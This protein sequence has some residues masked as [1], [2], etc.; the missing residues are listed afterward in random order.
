MRALHEKKGK[1][2]LYLLK[3]NPE[4]GAHEGQQWQ[5]TRAPKGWGLSAAALHLQAC[6]YMQTLLR[7]GFSRLSSSMVA[8]CVT[9]S[10]WR[11]LD[12]LVLMLQ[13]AHLSPWCGSAAWGL[14]AGRLIRSML[15]RR[16]GTGLQWSGSNLHCSKPLLEDLPVM[17]VWKEGLLWRTAH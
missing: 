7:E 12:T 14:N 3:P 13:D 1:A 15:Y 8:A 16:V 6:I 5:G 11:K 10:S 17:L 9:H 4:L 2:W